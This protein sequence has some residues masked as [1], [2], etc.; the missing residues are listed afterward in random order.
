MARRP[1]VDWGDAIHEGE[2]QPSVVV[3]GEELTVKAIVPPPPAG[4]YPLRFEPLPDHTQLPADDE[5][6]RK[7]NGFRPVPDHTQ[8]P[9]QDGTFVRNSYEPLQSH[10]LTE[11]LGP[12]LRQ[13][14]PDGNYFIGEDCGI[15]WRLTDP[16]ERGVKAPDWYCV[17]GVPRLLNGQMRRS[18][19]LWL[20]A[21]AP[22][23]NLEY[24]SGDG[25]EERDRTPGEGKFWVYETVLRSPFYGIYEVNAAKLEFFHA[26][27]GR[28]ELMPANERGR[29]PIA[30]LGVELGIWQGTFAN[31]E[32]PWLRWWTPQGQLVPTGEERARRLA[33]RLRGMGVDPDQV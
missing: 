2:K 33:E 14:D 22:L 10:L 25:A 15:Y 6:L 20:E 13:L 18:Y 30:A 11:T 32:L 31:Y 27:A 12:V 5:S 9:D 29:Y 17:L 4:P 21:I 23:L 19:V 16:P 3:P 26:V 7:K 24:V 28:Y 1:S 8:L